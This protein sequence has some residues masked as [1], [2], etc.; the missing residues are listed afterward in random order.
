MTQRTIRS[1]AIPTSESAI[2]ARGK[3]GFRRATWEEALELTAAAN[4]HTI[5]KWGLDRIAGFSPIPAMSMISY[6]S[7][8]RLMGLM[9][10]VSAEP[11]Q[12]LALCD[13]RGAVV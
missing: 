3:G 12:R 11:V 13:L 1:S 7:G 4:I 5:K 8:T 10:G 6:A 9:G 2:S